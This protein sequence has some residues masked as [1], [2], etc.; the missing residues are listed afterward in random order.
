MKTVGVPFNLR[1][2]RDKK[3]YFSND[4]HVGLHDDCILA[5]G[6]NGMDSGTFSKGGPW[7]DNDLTAAQQ[8]W[9]GQA[10][11]IISGGESCSNAGSVPTCVDLLNFV[12]TYSLSYVNIDYPESFKSFFTTGA[13]CAN[14]IS[15]SSADNYEKRLTQMVRK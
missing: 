7:P 10:G 15:K 12:Q 2:P 11:S 9:Q 6:L 4:N 3:L 5:Q 13:E 1:Y 8:Y 14:E